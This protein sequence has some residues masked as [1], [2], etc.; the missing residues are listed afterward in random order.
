MGAYELLK[1][2][3]SETGWGLNS[4]ISILLRFIED[5]ELTDELAEY[6]NRQVVTLGD[7]LPAEE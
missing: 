5:Q 7:Y 3:A 1:G 2:V 6:L 4:Q